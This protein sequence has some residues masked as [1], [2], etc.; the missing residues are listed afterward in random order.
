[1]RASCSGKIRKFATR[2]NFGASRSTRVWLKRCNDGMRMPSIYIQVGAIRDKVAVISS[3]DDA[4]GRTRRR[5]NS[6][7]SILK[8][9]L[10]TDF[11][12]SYH[13]LLLS[14]D[15]CKSAQSFLFFPMKSTFTVSNVFLLLSVDNGNKSALNTADT[16]HQETTSYY[17]SYTQTHAAIRMRNPFIM[18]ATL[19]HWIDNS[20]Y[21]ERAKKNREQRLRSSCILNIIVQRDNLWLFYGNY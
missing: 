17:A 9:S 19:G 15:F 18:N 8:A 7:T 2:I 21:R 11:K 4:M 10:F 6:V 16:R 13:L 12:S 3:F 20:I 5:E 14:I 1:M